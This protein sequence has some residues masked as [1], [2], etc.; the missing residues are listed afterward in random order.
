LPS[1][2][3]GRQPFIEPCGNQDLVGFE[4]ISSDDLNGD[5]NGCVSWVVDGFANHR[6]TYDR[7]GS[8][9]QT[10][11]HRGGSGGLRHGLVLRFRFEDHLPGGFGDHG[12]T[13]LRLGRGD[14]HGALLGFDLRP[15]FSPGRART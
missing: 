8:C 15:P 11:N 13:Y 7:R 14:R 3:H 5:L 10:R 4:E 2:P 1:N 12:R 6:V 9:D